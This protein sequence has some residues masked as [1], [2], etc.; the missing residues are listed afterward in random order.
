MTMTIKGELMAGAE[1]ADIR[2]ATL[3]DH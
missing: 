1:E 3:K 2:N